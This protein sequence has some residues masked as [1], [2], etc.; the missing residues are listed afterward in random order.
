MQ[1]FKIIVT[2]PDTVLNTLTREVK[3]I[4]P[5][6]QEVNFFCEMFYCTFFLLMTKAVFK[7]VL[8]VTK[9]VPALSEEVKDS[10]IKNMRRR[11]TPPTFEDSGWHWNEMLSIWWRSS[12]QGLILCSFY[13]RPSFL[14]IC[15]WF[16]LSHWV[17]N[18]CPVYTFFYL[19]CCRMPCE[20]LK[21]LAMMTVLLK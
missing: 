9:V 16:F 19:W 17:G 6:G 15:V 13:D 1:A 20:K 4:G 3:E 14:N 2:D 5:D 10:L 7:I 21:L 12:H 11:M 8:K 18:C